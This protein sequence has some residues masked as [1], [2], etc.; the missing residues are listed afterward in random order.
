[1][2]LSNLGF[3]EIMIIMGVILLVFGAKR[4]PEIG[5]S[6]GKGIREFQRSFKE[7]KDAVLSEDS[8]NRGSL[9]GDRG[10]AGPVQPPTSC[11][12][13]RLSN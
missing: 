8:S 12:P 4:L 5:A 9:E 1:M 10:A 3:M 7:T 6:M 2:S 13:K 11:E